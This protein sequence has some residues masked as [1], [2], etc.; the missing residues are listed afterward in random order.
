MID[1]TRIIEDYE[2]WRKGKVTSGWAGFENDPNFLAE[3]HT[4]ALEA[5]EREFKRVR[6]NANV[7]AEHGP[8]TA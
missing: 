4:V 8:V 2:S 3:A 5:V 1:W 6:E 7:L